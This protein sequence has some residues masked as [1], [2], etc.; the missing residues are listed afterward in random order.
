MV[1]RIRDQEEDSYLARAIHALFRTATQFLTNWT[2]MSKTIGSVFLD[3]F[4][5]AFHAKHLRALFTIDIFSSDISTPMTWRMV[6][7]FRFRLWLL[8]RSLIPYTKYTIASMTYRCTTT[9]V[10]PSTSVSSLTIITHWDSKS[11]IHWLII[12]RGVI[13]W[14]RPQRRLSTWHCFSKRRYANKTTRTRINDKQLWNTNTKEQPRL[15]NRI[16]I[17]AEVHFIEETSRHVRM[18]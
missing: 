17:P 12:I 11:Y 7:L 2:A 5:H 14:I 6:G 16:S 1:L 9:F 18:E 15:A 8:Q 10:I 4:I 13:R 3:H